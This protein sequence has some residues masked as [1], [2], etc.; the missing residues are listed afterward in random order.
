MKKFVIERNVSG[1]GKNDQNGLSGIAHKSN[2]AL[3][4]LSPRVQWQQSYVTADSGLSGTTR[5][6]AP[7]TT[8]SPSTETVVTVKRGSGVEL[9]HRFQ[10][11]PA[12]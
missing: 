11:V 12:A 2:D 4:K 5:T 8:D 7:P 9:T 1:V 6:P 10:R 3:A